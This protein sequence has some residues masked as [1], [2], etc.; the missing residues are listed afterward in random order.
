[1]KK[2]LG[3]GL[4]SLF[5]E[6]QNDELNISSQ[7]N[8]NNVEISINLLDRNDDQPRKKFDEKA[9]NELADSI[10]SYGIIQP[11]I[12]TKRGSR[13]LIV[14]GE[15]RFRAAKIAGIKTVPCIIK[16]MNDQEI[17]EVALVENLQREN[18]N[19]IESARAIQE[20]I[21][22][23]NLTQE[24]IA[25]KIG[26]SRPAVAN[27]LRLLSLSPEVI[28]FIEEDKLSSGHARVLVVIENEELQIKI[29]EMAIKAKLSVR[30]LEKYV[31]EIL[32]PKVKHEKKEQS[33]ELK[34][35][36]NDLQQKIKTKVT[37]L[38]NDKKGRILI[39][40]Y[41]QDDLQRLYEFLI[42]K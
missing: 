4:N 21:S 30:E 35:F 39:D 37:I 8:E 7:N 5:G 25:E 13:Y 20:L 17:R 34:Q 19:P 3:R 2:G 14:A 6:I 42:K 23:H 41:S 27:T 36:A 11:L 26:K 10:K 1:M 32:N 9:L 29:A 16:D 15:R 33:L 22:R 31:K 24:K 40:Y 38:G 28:K 18:L 12:V